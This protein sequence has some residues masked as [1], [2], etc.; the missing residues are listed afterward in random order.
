MKFYWYKEKSLQNSIQS[1]VFLWSVH[2][3]ADSA[4]LL[5]HSGDKKPVVCLF[6]EFDFILLFCKNCVDIAIEKTWK[7]SNVLSIT[8]QKYEFY[9]K[10]VKHKILSTFLGGIGYLL[11]EYLEKAYDKKIVCRL[12]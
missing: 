11:I 10:S 4:F 8:V 3:K 2:N 1:D 7:S 9:A 6:I 5:K 12:Y